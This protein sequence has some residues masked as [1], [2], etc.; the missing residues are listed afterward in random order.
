M[1]VFSM[2]LGIRS[3]FVKTL[4]FPVRHCLEQG[5]GTVPVT[6][7]D[8]QD[9]S[10]MFCGF[11]RQWNILEANTPDMFLLLNLYGVNSNIGGGSLPGPHSAYVLPSAVFCFY[12]TLT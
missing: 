1:D 6:V 5:F 4:E 10:G 9:F 11:E 3:S 12:L 8:E 2:D 7:K